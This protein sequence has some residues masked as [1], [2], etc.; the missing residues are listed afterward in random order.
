MKTAARP[1][2]AAKPR[3]APRTAKVVRLPVRRV[4]D[5]RAPVAAIACPK[6]GSIF[7]VLE[8]AF[9]HCRYCGSMTRIHS[10]SLLEQELFELRSGLRLAS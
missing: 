2:R 9:V 4:E 6:C 10:G 7:I 1:A 8:P 3:R 5:H